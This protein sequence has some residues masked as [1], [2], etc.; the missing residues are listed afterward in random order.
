MKHSYVIVDD[1][2]LFHML[3]KRKLD[4]IKDLDFYEFYKDSVSALMGIN[5]IRPEIIFMD[6]NIDTF[7]GPDILNNLEYT[8]SVIL[9]TSDTDIKKE[10]LPESVFELF[11]KPIHDSKFFESSVKYLLHMLDEDQIITA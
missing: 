10:N 9:M 2:P 8:P 6:Y 4:R 3:L 11:Y 5:K 7:N 1:D